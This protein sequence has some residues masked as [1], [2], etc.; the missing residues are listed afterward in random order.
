MQEES[1]QVMQLVPFVLRRRASASMEYAGQKLKHDVEAMF[2][3]SVFIRTRGECQ[4]RK[5]QSI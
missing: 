5:S 1:N 2:S 3:V 4:I